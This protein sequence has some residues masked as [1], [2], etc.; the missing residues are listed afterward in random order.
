MKIELRGLESSNFAKTRVLVV[1]ISPKTIGPSNGPKNV[2]LDSKR[3]GPI[4]HPLG[5]PRLVKTP[6]TGR[7]KISIVL[8]LHS[9]R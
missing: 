2:N 7:V 8:E 9:L 4:D 3:R 1:I 5:V 6:G